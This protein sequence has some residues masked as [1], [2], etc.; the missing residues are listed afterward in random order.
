LTQEC[1]EKILLKLKMNR[2]IILY[3]DQAHPIEGDTAAKIEKKIRQDWEQ[4]Q[5]LE[6]SSFNSYGVRI[7]FQEYSRGEA[8]VMELETWFE[9]NKKK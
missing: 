1:L 9:L 2:F 8:V 3:K 4:N 7:G 5:N 6:A